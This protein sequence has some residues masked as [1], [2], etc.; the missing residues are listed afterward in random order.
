[1]TSTLARQ[2]RQALAAATVLLIVLAFVAPAG[3]DGLAAFAALGC[4]TAFL[5]RDRLQVRRAWREE[6]ARRAQNYTVWVF[7]TV[8]IVL[9]LSAALSRAGP[10]PIQ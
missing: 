7:A 10:T 3:L 4:G 9:A 2:I 5:W 6:Y 8:L 1:M